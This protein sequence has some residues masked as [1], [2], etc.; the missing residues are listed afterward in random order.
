MQIAKWIE[1]FLP[2]IS[3]NVTSILVRVTKKESLPVLES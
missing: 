1:K 3:A 2:L